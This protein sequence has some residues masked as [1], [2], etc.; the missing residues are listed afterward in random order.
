MYHLWHVLLVYLDLKPVV[1]T[2]IYN[3]S[4]RL[5]YEDAW[6]R[7][8]ITVHILTL[9]KTN[10]RQTSFFVHS[11][12]ICPTNAYKTLGNHIY[13]TCDVLVCFLDFCMDKL[14]IARWSWA[15][16]A[17]YIPKLCTL[18]T[19]IFIVIL[20]V[21]LNLKFWPIWWLTVLWSVEL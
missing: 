14:H 10:Y 3:T 9:F 13:C 19:L 16:N 4:L 11:S 18:H 17:T 2:S 1:I 21:S 8:M 6:F 12:Y 20:M 5:L 15:N 7:S